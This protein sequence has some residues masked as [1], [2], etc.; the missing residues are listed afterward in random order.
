MATTPVVA[1][2]VPVV[3]VVVVVDEVVVVVVLEVAAPELVLE[4]F[5][6]SPSILTAPWKVYEDWSIINLTHYPLPFK[7][8]PL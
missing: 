1:G 3:L 6:P 8:K 2:W 7:L 5:E 4:L